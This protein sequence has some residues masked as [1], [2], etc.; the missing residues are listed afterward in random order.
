MMGS[1]LKAASWQ[2]CGWTSGIGAAGTLVT[3]LTK[4]Q[5]ERLR[6]KLERQS[7]IV[8]AER[9]PRKPDESELQFEQPQ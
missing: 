3:L 4:A 5:S 8:A 7:R 6:R 2:S 9:F 1:G